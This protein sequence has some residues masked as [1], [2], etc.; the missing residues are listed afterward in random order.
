MSS[1]AFSAFQ[2]LCDEQTVQLDFRILVNCIR[3][4]CCCLPQSFM[5][6]Y[7]HQSTGERHGKCSHGNQE[8]LVVKDKLEDPR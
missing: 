8:L 6:G 1:C 4:F 2:E 5:Q 3:L 7:W